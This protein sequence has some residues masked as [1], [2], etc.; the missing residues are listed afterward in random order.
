MLYLH[1]STPK[2]PAVESSAG[3]KLASPLSQE[4]GDTGGERSRTDGAPFSGARAQKEV[5]GG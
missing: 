1:P 2:A 5:L 4:A 3:F